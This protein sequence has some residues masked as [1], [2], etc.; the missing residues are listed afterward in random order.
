M[1][2]CRCVLRY[3]ANKSRNVRA[4]YWHILLCSYYFLSPLVCLCSR[5][6]RRRRRT[7]AR[8]HARTHGSSYARPLRRSHRCIYA[9]AG[10]RDPRVHTDRNDRRRRWPRR[11]HRLRHHGPGLDVPGGRYNARFTGL[12][13]IARHGTEFSL[14]LVTPG[15]SLIIP[16]LSI[17]RIIPIKTLNLALD[18][19][20]A[21]GH[22]AAPRAAPAR[23][24]RGASVSRR[25]LDSRAH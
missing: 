13:Q 10:E 20:G 3:R 19:P 9:N 14:I 15:S 21:Q 6:R 12:A 23:G 16:I 1:G 18:V 4:R 25:T 2:R 22:G 5:A 8:T 11:R 17:F 24:L 7:H